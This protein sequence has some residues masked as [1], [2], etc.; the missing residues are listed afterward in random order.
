[1]NRRRRNTTT[2]YPSHPYRNKFFWSLS[3]YSETQH[4]SSQELQAMNP[5]MSFF[6]KMAPPASLFSPAPYHILRYVPPTHVPHRKQT[7]HP[8][9]P[10]PHQLRHPPRRHRLP[11]LHQPKRPLRPHLVPAPDR[12]VE[13]P[14]P[15][16]LLTADGAPRGH[17]ADVPIVSGDPGAVGRGQPQDGDA[18]H[19]VDVRHG[20]GE[21]G[22]CLARGD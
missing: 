20:A 18:P 5:I 22:G 14:A 11:N 2:V 17:G 21:L 19:G 4:P 8:L 12:T 15:S 7:K 10:P 16:L 9:T 1:M 3:H 6:S 13:A